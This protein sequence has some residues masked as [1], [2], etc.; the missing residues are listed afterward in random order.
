MVH[1]P[2]ELE[3]LV[4]ESLALHFN[5][6]GKTYF[7]TSVCSFKYTFIP[8]RCI[9]YLPLDKNNAKCEDIKVFKE[10]NM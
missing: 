5:K 2:K 10:S 6:T 8:Q 9:E 1:V 4:L 7:K 3:D